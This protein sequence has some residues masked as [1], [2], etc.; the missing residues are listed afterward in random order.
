MPNFTPPTS[1]EPV[2]NQDSVIEFGLYC[3][4][5]AQRRST[6]VCTMFGRLLGCY[7]TY[8][9]SGALAPK[10]ILPGAKC[11]LRPSLAFSYI[12]SVIARYSDS[13][14]RASA[15]LCGMEQRMELQNFCR[16]RHLYSAG[17]PSCWAL[18]HILVPN[19]LMITDFQ[20][21]PVCSAVNSD[22]DP[23]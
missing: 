17:R 18:A 10:I 3:T 6:K 9:F 22:N 11:T 1:F 13:G 8:T 5:V 21:D 2:C 19:I 14:L 7:I 4:N 20:N 23:S 12:G 15:K 16:G